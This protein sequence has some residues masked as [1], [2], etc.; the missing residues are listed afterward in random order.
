M[1]GFGLYFLFAYPCIFSLIK[2][3]FPLIDLRERKGEGE[4]KIDVGEEH[5]PKHPRELN[6]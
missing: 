5:H 4:R 2:I 6:Q 1:I 3:F